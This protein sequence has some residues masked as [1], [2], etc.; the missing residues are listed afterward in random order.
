MHG[1]GA[2]V[3]EYQISKGLSLEYLAKHVALEDESATGVHLKK[4]TPKSATRVY[5]KKIHTKKHNRL[6]T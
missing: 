2:T 5:L 6:K 3:V 4:Y 1:G